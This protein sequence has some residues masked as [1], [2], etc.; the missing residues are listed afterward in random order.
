MNGNAARSRKLKRPIVF[1]LCAETAD[2]CIA[3]EEGGADRI[4]L[5]VALEVDGLTPPQSLIEKAVA[6]CRIPVHAMVRPHA[7]GFEYDDAT[8]SLMSRDIQSARSAGVQGIVLGLLNSSGTVDVD[9]TRALVELAYPLEVTFHRAF[10]AT[11]DLGQALEDVI[12]TGCHRILTSGGAPSV[13]AGSAMLARIVDRAA[14]RI[15]IA[16]GGGLRLRNARKVALS[17]GARHFHGSLPPENTAPSS[18][19]E[20]V[21]LMVRTLHEP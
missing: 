6:S 17:S 8:F 15:T 3:A 9:H 10:D 2:S 5:C 21:R 16:A 7:N 18:L 19:A 20:R 12:A 4:E 13:E 14:D 1:E 11:P